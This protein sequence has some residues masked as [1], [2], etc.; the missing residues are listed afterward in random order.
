M[1]PVAGLVSAVLL[2]RVV[3]PHQGDTV[4]E[5]VGFLARQPGGTGGVQLLK[6]SSRRPQS[7]VRMFAGFNHTATTRN[8][9][10]QMSVQLHPA[11]Y[12]QHHFLFQDISAGAAVRDQHAVP[13]LEEA[14][15]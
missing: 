12:K 13:G 2:C 10:A 1:E 15:C 4:S 5:D 3:I 8:H 7:R 14:V 9:Q 11:A 6:Q